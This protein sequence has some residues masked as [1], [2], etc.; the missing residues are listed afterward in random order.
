MVRRNPP[1]LQHVIHYRVDGRLTDS[2]AS[3]GGGS[4][5]ALGIDGV[6][7]VDCKGAVGVQNGVGH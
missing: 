6:N 4:E 2:V 3:P 5:R 1:Q 7:N